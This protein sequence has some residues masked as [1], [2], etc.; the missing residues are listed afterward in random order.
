MWF[1]ADS[2]RCVSLWKLD[3]SLEHPSLVTLKRC[4]CQHFW[5]VKWLRGL[6]RG[7]Y[8][9]SS[10]ACGYMSYQKFWWN[11]CI[12]EEH[13]NIPALP[14]ERSKYGQFPSHPVTFIAS[15]DASHV[16]W[17]NNRTRLFF[18]YSNCVCRTGG[19]RKFCCTEANVLGDCFFKC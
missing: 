9:C 13:R 2:R 18:E 5:P 19:L 7:K 15:C 16:N 1:W 8:S 4:C 3:S 14:Q 12:T 6:M 11:W 10:P 17:Q